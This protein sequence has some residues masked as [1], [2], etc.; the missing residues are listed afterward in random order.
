MH[1]RREEEKMEGREKRGIEERSRG[2]QKRGQK[3]Q[4]HMGGGSVEQER[5]GREDRADRVGE[6]REAE[7]LQTWRDGLMC[8]RKE[9]RRARQ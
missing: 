9:K 6:K 2:R 3:E 5:R 8:D 4:R 7:P 1:T